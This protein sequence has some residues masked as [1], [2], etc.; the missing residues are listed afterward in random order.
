VTALREPVSAETT[1]LP[2]IIVVA[3]AMLAVISG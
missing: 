1:A 2:C 3:T